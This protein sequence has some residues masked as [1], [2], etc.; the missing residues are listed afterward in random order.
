MLH[1]SGLLDWI[2]TNTQL[3]NKVSIFH[4]KKKKKLKIF[5][6]KSV[7]KNKENYTIEIIFCFIP[8][9]IAKI[10]G[11]K[12]SIVF[13]IINLRIPI[14]NNYLNEVSCFQRGANLLDIILIRNLSR[15]N[16]V[17]R[18]ILCKQETLN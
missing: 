1:R 6:L 11:Y 12:I 4:K 7:H 16:R 14:K 15:F 17:L 9:S 2:I 10:Y 18:Y 8:I 3:T 13:R 5:L